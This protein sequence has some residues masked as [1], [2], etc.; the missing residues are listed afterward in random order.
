MGNRKDLFD[1]AEKLG[2]NP[3]KN[4]TIATL[5][6]AIVGYEARNNQIDLPDP[7]AQ[8]A[9]DDGQQPQAGA[10]EAPAQ[11]HAPPESDAGVAQSSVTPTEPEVVPSVTV[12]GPRQGR[13]RIGHSFT[14][15][16][17]VIP[18][19]ELDDA[20]VEALRGDPLLIVSMPD[21]AD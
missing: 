4:A 15:E 21:N 9:A 14:A 20:Q 11:Q 10:N 3:A 18:L 16:P 5:K 1:Q 12:V 17:S 19:S 2:L 8:A 13:R 7:G 6:E